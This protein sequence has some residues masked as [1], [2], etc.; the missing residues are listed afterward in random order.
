MITVID[1]ET[2]KVVILEAR[3]VMM[4]WMMLMTTTM[5]RRR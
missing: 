2:M 4:D 1:V 5:R 3:E